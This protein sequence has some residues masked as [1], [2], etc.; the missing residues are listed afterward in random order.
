MSNL[1]SILFDKKIWSIPL[2]KQWLIKHHYHPIKPV[3]KTNNYF[4]YRLKY[5]YKNNKY[6]TIHLGKN[7]GI[8]AI[9]EY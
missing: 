2:S 7:T 5:P 1:Q 3:H 9:L 8:K 4:R 6:R